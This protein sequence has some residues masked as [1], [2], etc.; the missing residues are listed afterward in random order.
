MK[1]NYATTERAAA[2]R[3]VSHEGCASCCK[4]EESKGP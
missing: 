1:V 3:G 4:R 2:E